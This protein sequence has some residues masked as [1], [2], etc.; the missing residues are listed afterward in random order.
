MDPLVNPLNIVVND[1]GDTTLELGVGSYM[2]INTIA[3][4]VVNLSPSSPKAA[5]L[6]KSIE[7][8]SNSN[9]TPI[10]QYLWRPRPSIPEILMGSRLVVMVV[11]MNHLRPILKIRPHVKLLK[12]RGPLFKQQLFL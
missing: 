8:D 4:Q 9:H 10:N 3:P 2:I 12:G 11:S 1:T 7:G 6:E 5:R